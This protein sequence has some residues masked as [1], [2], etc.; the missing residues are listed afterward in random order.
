[1]SPDSLSSPAPP[2]RML[3]SSLPVISSLPKPVLAFSKAF[4]ADSVRFSVPLTACASIRARLSLISP[5]LAERSS[6]SVPPKDSSRKKSP[7]WL[8]L[9]A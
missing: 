5:A 1:M 7:A 2:L 8:A 3:S 6:V 4:T 9:N